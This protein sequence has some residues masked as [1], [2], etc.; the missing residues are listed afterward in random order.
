[1]KRYSAALI[2][3][4][5]LSI[6]TV[7]ANLLLFNS[8]EF[9]SIIFGV[10]IVAADLLII[11][12]TGGRRIRKWVYSVLSVIIICAG[13]FCTYCNPYWNSTNFKLSSDIFCNGF[14][15]E[16]SSKDAVADLDYA[17]KYLKK[18]HPL[19]KDNVPPDVAKQYEKVKAELGAA[20]KVDTCTL[21][22]KIESVFSLL[23]DAHTCAKA[24]EKN[25]HYLKYYYARKNEGLRLIK[26]NGVKL[27][28]LLRSKRSLY[29]FEVENWGLESLQND[30]LTKEGLEYLG[31]TVDNGVAYTYEDKDG[32]PKTYL[33]K[34]NDFVTKTEYY[35]FNNIKKE[36]KP[37]VSYEIDKDHNLAVLT[38][39]QC[40]DDDVYKKCVRDM[41]TE[42]K[43]QG[44]KNVA[45]D[46]RDN[47]G[48]SSLV[49]DEFI[50]YLDVDNYRQPVYTRRF[51]FLDF[52]SGDG[53]FT[54]Q[55]YND[56]L[57]R[58]NV[59]LLTS[60]S[61]FSSAMDFAQYIKDNKLGTIIGKPPANKPAGFGE[62]VEMKL[63][64][65]QIFMQI[66]TTRFYRTDPDCKDELVLPDTECESSDA[67]SVL[68]SKLVLLSKLK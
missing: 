1:M 7:A 26:V 65:S 19:F 31:I 58:G 29:S 38:L 35:T 30:L 61:T 23:G 63:P 15:Q 57:F 51:G 55:K 28:E 41:F 48:G 4:F 2:V 66:S 27:D 36:N 3:L 16:L 5:I 68:Q 20:G 34:A 44:I 60:E 62:C 33:Y 12:K 32:N 10:L 49:A 6:S 53:N 39:T 40:N 52:T 21:S 59:Y 43:K 45:V 42:V 37:F 11:F 47:G 67:L 50:S 64:H 56:L 22:Q 24:L 13:L 14:N 8:P 17:M 25:E 18:D 54:N 9:I 46:L